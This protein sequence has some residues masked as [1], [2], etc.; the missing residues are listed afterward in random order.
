LICSGSSITFTNTSDLGVTYS[1]SNC[2]TNPPYYWSV[3]G[4]S[5][6]TVISGS[7]GS[8]NGFPN[9][10]DGWDAG[11][12]TVT[13]QFT[14][15]GSYQMKLSIGNSCGIDDTTISFSVIEESPAISIGI[16]GNTQ[17]CGPAT[18]NFSL[19]SFDNNHF[20][21]TYTLT[22]SDGSSPQIF[23]HPPPSTVTHTF[24][25]SSCGE[26]SLNNL[27][28]AFWFQ[29]TAQ[30]LCD[31]AVSTIE[32]I[33]ISTAPNAQF[34]ALPDPV[35]INSTVTV[36]ST[37]DPG[38]NV[39][40]A[41]CNT[42][43]GMVWSISPATGW[44]LTS[45]TLGSVNAQPNNYTAWTSGSTQ[46]QLS[47]SVAGNYTITQR[48]R[49]SCGEDVATEIVCV[50]P[51]LTANFTL[52]GAP[53]APSVLS[54]DNLT[55]PINTCVA[56]VYV[57]SINPIAPFDANV[58][59][60]T[61][62][63]FE[64]EWLLT[65][66][67]LYT[68]NL[69]ATNVCG[70]STATNNFTIVA[71][72]DVNLTFVPPGCAPYTVDPS[73]TYDDGGETITLQQWQIN[74]GAWQTITP[75]EPVDFPPQ[76][77]NAG[78]H[79]I[80]V[81][82][83]NEC[84]TDSSSITVTVTPLP[85]VNAGPDANVCN[86]PNPY[87]L[88]GFSPT[89]GTW[90]G[91]GVTSGGV[92]TPSGVGT[93]TLTYTVTQNGCTASDQVVLIVTNPIAANA[94][95]DQSVCLNSA[96][97]NLTGSPIGGDWSGMG[98]TLGGVFTPSSVG[99]FTLTYSAGT[100]N[101]TVTDI[102]AITVLALPSVTVA[103]ETICA[104]QNA[105]LTA[106]G[107]G[108]TAPYSYSWSPA[109]G[110]SATSGDVVIANP[111]FTQTYT[112]TITSVNTCTTTDQATVTVTPLPVIDA[113]V[114]Q[115]ICLDLQGPLVFEGTPAGGIWSGNPFI[116]ASGLFIPVEAGLFFM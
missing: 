29:I 20:S 115:N 14:T 49:N 90:S 56:P 4:P 86:T 3:N 62:N 70:T 16:A 65:Q 23:N 58:P 37:A 73:V 8:N 46:L 91:T 63:S 104:G 116:T 13:M 112:V 60:F 45:G 99:S 39:N 22:F 106:I 59:P 87:T 31:I 43:H 71:P 84:G 64:P 15:P 54:T 10:I 94:G 75:A 77:F 55:T 48:I 82:I 105:T 103:D 98:V 100:G 52:S 30:N 19:G 21:T 35:C 44:T 50:V 68:I 114:N 11:S 2:N 108:G 85:T 67:G 28:D 26:T 1:G 109:T 36:N 61:A 113:G 88:T 6:G 96:P 93:V 24:T 57:W 51:P 17:Q 102:K 95:A 80:K 12:N 89:G 33:R 72:P 107:S 27:P 101:C 53:C 42:N 32:P 41:G 40:A 110:L 34:T 111:T 81:R 7:L 47:F 76:V 66:E 97:I 25:Q 38:T 83:T 18:I 9:N 5:V 74:G 79:T 92:F 69:S 78:T